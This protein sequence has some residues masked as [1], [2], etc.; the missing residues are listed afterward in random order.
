MSKV[1]ILTP[2]VFKK[3]L[4][5]PAIR[6]WEM[7]KEISGTNSVRLASVTKVPIEI[8][9]PHFE[10]LNCYR[11]RHLRNQLKWADVVIVQ[12]TI[13]SQ[14]S[15][16]LRKAKHLVVDLYDPMHLE[17]LEQTAGM[18]LEK[19]VSKI[20]AVADTLNVQIDRAD[21]MLCASPK[22]RDFWLG[23]LAARG[24]INPL[25]YSAHGQLAKLIQVVPFGL[26]SQ[27]PVLTKPAIKGVIPGI[28]KDD[29]V[30]IWGGGLYNWFDPLTL[31][32]AMP[33]VLKTHPRARLFFM[34]SG[35]PNPNVPQMS[36]AGEASALAAELGLLNQ[37]VFFNDEWV[38]YE[39]RAQYLL[40]AD[41]GV[42]T[43]MVHLETEFS[44]RTRILDYLWAGLPM[45]VSEGDY[46]ASL[47]E[48]HGLGRVAKAGDIND[49]SEALTKLLSNHREL[50]SSA[51]NSL[52]IAK[53]FEWPTVLKPLVEYCNNPYKATDH[54]VLRRRPPLWR[55]FTSSARHNVWGWPIIFLYRLRSKIRQLFNREP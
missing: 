28:S 30:I 32:K 50:A 3:R 10:L 5:G 49:L 31:I 37:S 20:A 29:R 2:D 26:D 23:Q 36:I 39:Q 22:Q 40:D 24:R 7:A 4:A 55:A 1:L 16:I 8:T 19:R 18:P 11:S 45:V 34:G 54:S 43:H 35:H 53:Q 9:H 15:V 44:F 38:E 46:F 17:L 12:G 41:I 42:S 47:V 27:F 21:L 13:T 6:A 48:L 14:F 25:T 33:S 52:V 51:Q